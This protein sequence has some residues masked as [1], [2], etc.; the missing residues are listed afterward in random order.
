MLPQGGTMTA[1]ELA[2]STIGARND[3]RACERRIMRMEEP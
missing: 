1:R 3:C 2:I